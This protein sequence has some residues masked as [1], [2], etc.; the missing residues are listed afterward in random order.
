MRVSPYRFTLL[1]LW[2]TNLLNPGLICN[3]VH[4]TMKTSKTALL[5]AQISVQN[6]G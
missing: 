1:C 3:F 2:H 6:Q 4:G 5:S